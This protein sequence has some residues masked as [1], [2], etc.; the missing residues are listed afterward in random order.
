MQNTSYDTRR[1]VIISVFI[2]VTVVY[3]AKLFSIQV[4]DNQ[5]KTSASSN[6]LRYVTQYPVRGL[7]YDRHNELV[8]YNQ[9]AYDLMVIPRQLSAFDT[10]EFCS[11]LNINKEYAVKKL[12]KAKAYSRYKPSVFLKQVSAK[13]YAIWQE[14]MY[15]FPG[16]FTQT[17]TLRKYPD[18]TAAHVVGYV[19]EVNDRIIK[20]DPYYKSGDYIGISGIE[21]SY[22]KVLRG[23]KGVK[24]FMVD[25]H[26]RIKGTYKNGEMDREAVPGKNI[27]LTLDVDL[28]AYGEK[29]MHN[30]K[31]SIV[32]IEPQTGEILCMVSTPDYNPGLLSGRQ[33]T[34]N[35]RK[36]QKDTLK[37]LFNRALQA[38]YPPGSTF[39]ALNALIGLQ[40][41]VVSLN[42]EYTCYNGYHVGNFS[43]GCHNHKTPLD[44]KESIQYSCNAYYCHVFRNILDQ[45][46]DAGIKTN[47]QKWREM[48]LS[49]GYGKK[50]NI[51]FPFELKGLIPKASYFENIYG[52]AWNSLNIVSMAIGQGEIL[53][54][55]LQM[56]NFASVIA[57]RGYYL[58]PH[59]VKAIQGD[60]TIAPKYKVK[61][62]AKVD[63]QHFE[64][65][66]EGMYN[67]VQGGPG[68]TA[69]NASV[70]SLEICGKTGTAE[71]P[72]GEDHS[73]FIAFAP[74]DN[75][76]IAVSVYV[77]NGGYGATYAAPIAS[78]IIE[79]YLKGKVD[80]N[81]YEQ[82]ILKANLLA[83]AK[84][85]KDI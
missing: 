38:Q 78:F 81:W 60:T 66:V 22:E 23:K 58:I 47:Y 70:D 33:R 16:F 43:L 59:L 9:A 13:T 3:I 57:N 32:A 64:P 36:L 48:T 56:A 21:K 18:S 44:F 7:M 49:F 73:I 25:V 46:S 14:Q 31:G 63:K 72:H 39:K 77:E 62:F 37:P 75:P 10:T 11:I 40:T 5:Y 34:R 61:R 79:K 17:R 69:R 1:L 52:R 76:K 15:K 4:K 28:Q 30:K 42:T 51:D 35:Y 8:V 83:G 84:K 68:S 12:N 67:V 24:V 50:L 82:Y 45:A 41:G 65:V 80:R 74:K 26:N 54:T 29:L 27:T 2:L 55:P 85:D 20:K 71:N 6:V 53:V 19:G